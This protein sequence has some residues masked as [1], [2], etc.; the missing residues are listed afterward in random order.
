MFSVSLP[1][2]PAVCDF[3]SAAAAFPADFGRDGSWVCSTGSGGVLAFS[4][5]A[6][7]Y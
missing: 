7:R 4:D 5:A 6:L 2:S 3:S 1:S